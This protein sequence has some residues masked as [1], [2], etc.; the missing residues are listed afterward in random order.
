MAMERVMLAKEAHEEH[1]KAE[2]QNVRNT[3]LSSV[4]HDLRSPLAVVAG[5][6]S[7]L[8][9]KDASLDRSARLELLHTIHEETDRLERIIRNVLNL[10]RLDS[11]AITVHKEWQPLEEIIGVILN[12]FSDRLRERSLELKIPPDLPLI[13]F[14]TLLMEQVLSNLMENALRHTP[15]GTP[16]EITVT[17]QKSAV[18]IEIADRGPGIP[19]HEEEAI[20][21]KFTRGTNTQMGAGIGLSI[22]RVIVEAHG[23]RIW[24]ENRPGGGA[25]FKFVIPVEGTPPSM[26]PE[27][28]LP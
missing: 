7:T 14:D 13:P 3:F 12:R 6:A 5:A 16:V 9:E 2:A 18:M 23:G 8:L 26:I 21:R 1:L 25:A 28:E 27:K 4:S 17:P 22:C 19:A 20:F 15:T 11:G 24:A 10:T